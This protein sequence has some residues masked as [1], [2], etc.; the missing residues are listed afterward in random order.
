M[1]EQVREAV[2]DIVAEH[3]EM[4]TDQATRFLQR[5]E[6]ERRLQEETW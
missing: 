1:P 5:L 4:D 6:A 2:R 3:G